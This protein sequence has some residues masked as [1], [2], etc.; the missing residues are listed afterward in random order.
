MIAVLWHYSSSLIQCES[1][2]AEVWAWSQWTYSGVLLSVVMRACHASLSCCIAEL[3]SLL[4]LSCLWFSAMQW[5]F[6][7]WTLDNFSCLFSVLLWFRLS[8]RFL[9]STLSTDNLEQNKWSHRLEACSLIWENHWWF[10]FS[11]KL[12]LNAVLLWFFTFFFWYE[13]TVLNFSWINCCI[14]IR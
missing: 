12:F 6:R 10:Q 14:K 2:W 8:W 13:L 7:N 3:S 9:K 4:L 11:Q 1:G 5:V